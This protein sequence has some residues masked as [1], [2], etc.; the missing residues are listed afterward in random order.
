MSRAVLDFV[1]KRAKRAETIYSDK[2]LQRLVAS[3]VTPQ[4]VRSVHTDISMYPHSLQSSAMGALGTIACHT[5]R[6]RAIIL[7]TRIVQ[8]VKELCLKYT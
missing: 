8:W 2:P 7:R 4:Q 6:A 1:K 5:H 3:L